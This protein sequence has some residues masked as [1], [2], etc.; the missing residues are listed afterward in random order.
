M[1]Q[2]QLIS[3][4]FYA[5][6][7]LALTECVARCASAHDAAS[8]SFLL[9][10]SPSPPAFRVTNSHVARSGL[11]SIMICF[12]LFYMCL[13]E[14]ENMYSIQHDEE[15]FRTN[16][17]LRPVDLQELC[18]TTAPGTWPFPALVR[19]HLAL[20]PLQLIF[21]WIAF[22]LLFFGYA[23]GGQKVIQIY[24]FVRLDA[25]DGVLDHKL[26][27]TESISAR[28]ARARRFGRRWEYVGENKPEEGEE[29]LHVEEPLQPER[30]QPDDDKPLE[31]LAYY[32][33]LKVG[34]HGPFRVG[35]TFITFSEDEWDVIG[36][37]NELTHKSLIRMG[38]SYFKPHGLT[39]SGL[40]PDKV[41]DVQVVR[42]LEA[43]QR[44]AKECCMEEKHLTLEA[45]KKNDT[46]DT[47]QVEPVSFVRKGGRMYWL[48]LYDVF[49]VFLGEVFF[50]DVRNSVAA[51]FQVEN[52]QSW[53]F[54]Y[55]KMYY[56]N[57]FCAHPSALFARELMIAC[58][59]A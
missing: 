30:T 37:R 1:S 20:R 18:V 35:Y 28:R 12:F 7:Y 19:L 36:I 23:R 4:V 22:A 14:I 44:I 45:L 24:E 47:D 21:T 41:S 29:L 56:A 32:F 51:L 48:A 54:R 46:G 13:Y 40:S 57:T 6:S 50:G 2:F 39:T 3:Y 55:I 17:T 10:C 52:T 25:A 42:S 11:M 58:A 38:A 5:K 31:K 26:D 15:F 59:Q 43:A 49:A 9:P 27:E 16:G 8:L 34:S 53:W 33:S